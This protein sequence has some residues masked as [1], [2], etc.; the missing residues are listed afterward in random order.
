MSSFFG[1]IWWENQ[2]AQCCICHERE[3]FSSVPMMFDSWLSDVITWADGHK[4]EECS[5]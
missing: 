5:L 4:H 2:I 1:N 3:D